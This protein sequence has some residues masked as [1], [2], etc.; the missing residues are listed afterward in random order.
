MRPR[1][2]FEST[3]AR[4]SRDTFFC[5]EV[6]SPIPVVAYADHIDGFLGGAFGTLGTVLGDPG[7]AL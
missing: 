2:S 3:S 6:R 4:A 1:P 7:P 5:Y